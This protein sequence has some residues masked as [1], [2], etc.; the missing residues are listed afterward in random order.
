MELK[1]LESNADK[2]I[3]TIYDLILKNSQKIA[4]GIS[5]KMNYFLKVSC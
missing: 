3:Q 4:N 1:G 5:D 2:D